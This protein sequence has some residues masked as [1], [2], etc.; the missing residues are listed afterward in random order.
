MEIIQKTRE[1]LFSI[2]DGTKE[3]WA[4]WIPIIGRSFW[5]GFLFFLV[6]LTPIEGIRLFY[7]LRENEFMFNEFFPPYYLEAV[8]TYFSLIFVVTM[9]YISAHHFTGVKRVAEKLTWNDIGIKL[10][11][12]DENSIFAY[13]IL[14]ES[15]KPFIVNHIYAEITW[16][17]QDYE[18]KNAN[19]LPLI[20]GR[21][22]VWDE[23]VIDDKGGK[24]IFSLF[25]VYRDY[26][27]T[28]NFRA[29][30]P[31]SGQPNDRDCSLDIVSTMQDK[32]FIEI[33]FSCTVENEPIIPSKI[34]KHYK[35]WFE[36][37]KFLVEEYKEA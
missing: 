35:A 17:R 4:F 26:P 8:A 20:Y 19:R 11:R 14:F 3:T 15:K 30:M 24:I 6:T 21:Q 34:K 33:V 22:Y 25:N 13:G 36:G 1:F 2:V 23:G 5:V 10:K 32:T 9:L 28:E 29:Y 27:E 18:Y 7:Y 31:K 12:F 16:H 37:N